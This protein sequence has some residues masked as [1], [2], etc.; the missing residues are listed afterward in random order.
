[1]KESLLLLTLLIILPSTEAFLRCPL[2]FFEA[3]P[4]NWEP[5]SEG[6]LLGMHNDTIKREDCFECR[7][8]G[9]D[10]A[11]VNNGLVHVMKFKDKWQSVGGGGGLN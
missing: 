10:M 7:W 8:Y 1:M 5:I 3:D 11:A 4:I 9:E 2:K 6:Y